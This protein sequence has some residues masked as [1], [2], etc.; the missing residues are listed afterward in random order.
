MHRYCTKIWVWR[1]IYRTLYWFK[2]LSNQDLYIYSIGFTIFL[3]YCPIPLLYAC[4]AHVD[5]T[6]AYEI[7]NLM[8]FW[9][10]IIERVFWQENSEVCQTLWRE[11]TTV[12]KNF[13]SAWNRTRD[14]QYD[15]P[16]RCLP[17]S[18]SEGNIIFINIILWYKSIYFRQLNIHSVLYK[19]VNY[20]IYIS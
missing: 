4:G 10:A 13:C 12:C 11:I 9:T 15:R 17:S 6:Q 5:Y 8:P 19:S 7:Y 18:C 2:K 16:M 14:F 1:N 3:T 20:I